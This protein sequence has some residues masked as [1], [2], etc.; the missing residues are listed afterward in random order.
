MKNRLA[1]LALTA[2]MSTA[3]AWADWQIAEG[4]R[5]QFVSIKQNKIGEISHFERITGAVSAQGQ[6]DI[7]ISLDSLETMIGIRNQRMKDLLFEVGIYPEAVITSQLSAD[8]L[9]LVAAEQGGEVTAD[10]AIDLH[11]DT[12]TKPVKLLVTPL[13]D[14]LAVSTTEPILI[15]ASEF[16]LEPGVAALQEVAGLLAIS[17]VVPV[18]VSLRLAES[19]G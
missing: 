3:P 13:S 11:G 16:G 19:G 15:N 1:W 14:G 9:A 18:T 12:V 6:V 10:I 17:R 8:A 2:L 7:R 5:I 4:S